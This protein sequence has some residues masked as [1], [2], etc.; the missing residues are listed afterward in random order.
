[1]LLLKKGCCARG[2]ALTSYR[3]LNNLDE[4]SSEAILRTNMDLLLCK[5]SLVLICM[6]DVF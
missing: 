2:G 6:V 3:T 5:R 1:M 4:E